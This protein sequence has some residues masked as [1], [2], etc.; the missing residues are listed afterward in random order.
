MLTPQFECTQDTDTLTLRIRAPHVRSSHL[1]TLVL[2]RD[3]RFHCK[4]YFLALTFDHELVPDVDDTP[5]EGDVAAASTATATA[6]DATRK[7]SASYDIVSG[8]FTFTLPKLVPGTV[9]GNLDMLTALLTGANGSSVQSSSGQAAAKATK[10]PL[11][12]SLGMEDAA[13]AQNDHEE[14]YEDDVDAWDWTW[15]QQI[16]SSTDATIRLGAAKYGFADHFSGFWETHAD[17]KSELLDLGLEPDSMSAAQRDAAKREYE[18]EEFDEDRYMES[19]VFDADTAKAHLKSRPWWTSLTAGTPLELT[20]DEQSRLVRIA[21]TMAKAPIAVD[22]A[23]DSPVLLLATLDII[24]SYALAWRCEDEDPGPEFGWAVARVSAVLGAMTVPTSPAAV[25][26]S[27]VRR[28]L[29]FPYLR[30][31]PLA[32][33]AVLDAAAIVT[34]GRRPV[35]RALLAVH[36]AFAADDVR[37]TLNRAWIEPLTQWVATGWKSDDRWRRAAAKMTHE[38]P[39][40]VKDQVTRVRED[41]QLGEWEALAREVETGE[42]VESSED[43]VENGGADVASPAP[44]VVAAAV[45]PQKPSETVAPRGPLISVVGDDADLSTAS[46]VVPAVATRPGTDQ[47]LLALDAMLGQSGQDDDQDG[48]SDEEIGMKLAGLSLGDKDPEA[49]SSSGVRRVLISEL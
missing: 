12:E 29:L 8:Y 5:V 43:E 25:A 38:W 46:P 32:R 9:F 42:L 37:W 34:A 2:G 6:T 20:T 4:P 30:S 17:E 44:P 22:A 26:E 14:E 10:G 47:S 35:L 24:A 36:A 39:S 49:A 27:I 1:E 45:A 23:T 40:V 41:W 33:A 15:E 21:Q 11:I 18:D 48:Q 7:P 31:V 19:F 3:F 16:P 28:S 13:A